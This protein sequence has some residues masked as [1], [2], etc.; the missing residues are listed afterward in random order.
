MSQ[1]LSENPSFEAVEKFRQIII[2]TPTPTDDPRR[3]LSD[4]VVTKAESEITEVHDNTEDSKE[5]AKVDGWQKLSQT[6]DE[7][8][9]DDHLAQSVVSQVAT[10][11]QDSSQTLV[12]VTADHNSKKSD[13]QS[14]DHSEYSH[15]ESDSPQ[16][17]VTYV[18][19]D[20]SEQPQPT[21]EQTQLK[22]SS[23]WKSKAGSVLKTSAVAV[24]AVVAAPIV[25][26]ALGASKLAGKF[27]K[28]GSDKSEY[29]GVPT[30]DFGVEIISPEQERE[31]DFTE[32]EL[33]EFAEL[34]R[35]AL[36][37]S[38]ASEFTPVQESATSEFTPV[39]ES[40]TSEFTPAT[41]QSETFEST[42]VKQSES[43]ESTLR[44]PSQ[45]TYFASVDYT[46]TSEFAPV[47]TEE[48]TDSASKQDSKS[49]EQDFSPV[50]QSE[51]SNSTPVNQS[52][53]TKATSLQESSL[54]PQ[55]LG[56]NLEFTSD[57]KEGKVEVISKSTTDSQRE[58]SI[59]K[60]DL[61]ELDLPEKSDIIK[62]VTSEFTPVSEGTSKSTPD[63]Q[64]DGQPKVSAEYQES[65]QSSAQSANKSSIFESDAKDTT[66]FT[67]EAQGELS[68]NQPSQESF[69]TLKDSPSKTPEGLNLSESEFQESSNLKTLDQNSEFTPKDSSSKSKE[70]E[71]TSTESQKSPEFAP[72]DPSK[73]SQEQIHESNSESAPSESKTG[74]NL[75]ISEDQVDF[76]RKVDPI[77]EEF[78][79]LT[80]PNT[81]LTNVEEV[82]T[83]TQKQSTKSTTEFTPHSPAE[84]EPLTQVESQQQ[85]HSKSE[86]QKSIWEKA[87][88]I[89]IPSPQ[90]ESEEE[91]LTV[92]SKK[93][94]D[95]A[96][97]EVGVN[98]PKAISAAE[99][100]KQPRPTVQKGSEI[101]ENQVSS[102]SFQE[103]SDYSEETEIRANFGINKNSEEFTPGLEAELQFTKEA[104]VYED[105]C[106]IKQHSVESLENS[107]TFQESLAQAQT[108]EVQSESTWKSKAS[109]VLKTSAIA[110]GAVAASAIVLPALGA[111]ALAAAGGS[112]ASAIA[113]A[114][115]GAGVAGATG[116]AGVT[117]T[118][119]ATAA[120]AS[121]AVG[122]A[123]VKS[124][125]SEA[126]PG[127][128][129]SD[130][131][132]ETKGQEKSET[133]ET[134]DNRLLSSSDLA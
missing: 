28:S 122:V 61:L 134:D 69:A 35:Q 64:D 50:N 59:P 83:D 30:E 82:T 121:T 111:S 68:D 113:T 109:V 58:T 123:A 63:Q 37:I 114:S 120:A 105:A 60:Q 47:K 62:P 12:T 36:E 13:D 95:Q 67:P 130:T 99:T 131:E 16:T 15:S 6:S 81:T 98:S 112:A 77:Q 46:E 124:V 100:E 44:E 90:K 127:E 74:T 96:I 56:Q 5:I 33:A 40:K 10:F 29:Q 41:E 17:G 107:P 1:I 18:F 57:S 93:I 49:T 92:A 8:Y 73:D 32:Q 80:Q 91:P 65:S 45:T 54:K 94:N 43:T 132:L 48:I 104:Q 39:Q 22:K 88:E 106:L 87:G 78:E 7:C 85:S 125:S 118:G 71:Q 9:Q 51:V 42:A 76:I 2:Q 97:S 52:E 72:C 3:S 70:F 102:C 20:I 101:A 26:P 128:V 14:L 25:L 115:A 53:T 23:N 19:E 27:R 84:E 119:I 55:H 75:Y 66:D 34:K 129:H 24:G 116:A 108:S 110:V 21:S 31:L 38:K 86:A 103:G 126:E 79:P 11:R 117:A 89:D 133:A 4:Q